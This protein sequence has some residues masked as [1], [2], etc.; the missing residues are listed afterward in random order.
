[1]AITEVD[2]RIIELEVN[3]TKALQ[4]LKQFEAQTKKLQTNMKAAINNCETCKC[5]RSIEAVN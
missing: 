1:M 2:K 3:A 5:A 4:P